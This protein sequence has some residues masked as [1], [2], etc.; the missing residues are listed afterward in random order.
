MGSTEL[1]IKRGKSVYA[2]GAARDRREHV[3][4]D[5]KDD[6]MDVEQKERECEARQEIQWESERQGL[7]AH[8]K[9]N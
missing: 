9:D 8:A 4:K 3:Y 2:E 1:N 6:L 7:D 5:L